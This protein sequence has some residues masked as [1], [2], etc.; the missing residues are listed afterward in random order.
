MSKTA[1]AF[2]FACIGT[3]SVLVAMGCRANPAPDAGFL[4]QPKRLQNDPQYRDKPYTK[5]YVAPVNT[6][7]VMKENLWEMA[8][9]TSL[10]PD[11][12]RQNL[13]NLADY[14]RDA[15][16]KAVAKYANGKLIVVDRPDADT[17]ILE[18]AIVQLVP[19]KVVLQAASYYS[20][21]ATVVMI[22]G[23]VATQSEDQGKGVVAMEARTRDGATGVVTSMMADREHPP[24]AIIDVKALFWWEPAKPICD[25]WARQIIELETRP[26]GTKIDGIPNF[27]WLVW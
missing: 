27:K 4:Q 15:V 9:L 23:S 7:Y 13:H 18:I 25:G 21:I 3:V 8:S 2:R 12:V 10:N 6:D 14:Q 22:G 20:W 26:R 11:Y 24:Q 1:V 17:L 19:S 16:I 5:I